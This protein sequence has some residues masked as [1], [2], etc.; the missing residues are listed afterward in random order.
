MLT[1]TDQLQNIHRPQVEQVCHITLLFK[2]TIGTAQL[3][4]LKMNLSKKYHW[5]S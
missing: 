1:P 5:V 3:A 2:R 4:Q